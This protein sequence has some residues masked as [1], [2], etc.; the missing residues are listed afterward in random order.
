MG[1]FYLEGQEL[2]SRNKNLWVPS[3]IFLGLLKHNLSKLEILIILLI[4]GSYSTRRAFS[5]IQI[6][7]IIAL[8]N[9]NKCYTYT[10]FKRLIKKKFIKHLKVKNRK[11]YFINNNVDEW[12]AF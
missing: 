9:S 3:S 12:E 2:K 1:A 6:K 5:T 7:D 11:V 8:T 10:V 4:L